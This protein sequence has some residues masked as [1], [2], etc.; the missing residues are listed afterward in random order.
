MVYCFTLQVLIQVF[1]MILSC[2]VARLKHDRYLCGRL[3]D[4]MDAK[5]KGERNI[6][7]RLSHFPLG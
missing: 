7:M 4:N 1:L 5:G 2:Y 3:K 6:A